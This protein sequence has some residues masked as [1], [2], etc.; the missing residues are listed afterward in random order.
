MDRSQVEFRASSVCKGMA[1][2][3]GT[4]VILRSVPVRA[5]RE[6]GTSVRLSSVPI[7]SRRGETVVPQTD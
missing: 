1:G 4:V 2:D 6:T 3:C 5:R 7:R